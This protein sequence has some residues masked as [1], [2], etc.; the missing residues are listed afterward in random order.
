MHSKGVVWHTQSVKQIHLYVTGEAHYTMMKR[1][2]AARAAWASE[3]ALQDDVD[4]HYVVFSD[5]KKQTLND[6][7]GMRY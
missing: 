1:H 7:D 3:K 2:K 6:P 5:E 4:W